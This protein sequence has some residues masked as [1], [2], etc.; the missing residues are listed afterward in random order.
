MPTKTNYDDD[1]YY[2]GDEEDMF[3]EELDDLDGDWMDQAL[4]DYEKEK[5]EEAEREAMREI[6]NSRRAEKKLNQKVEKEEV[7]PEDIRQEMDA[8]RQEANS[9][10][11]AAASV[12]DE[13]TY[14]ADM[15]TKTKED[16]KALGVAIAEHILKQKDRP[17]FS[18]MI[19][20]LYSAL[21]SEFTTSD[22]VDSIYNNVNAICN[23]TKKREKL[24][25]RRGDG[26]V[27]KKNVMTANPEM[28]DFDGSEEVNAV[29]DDSEQPW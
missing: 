9:V 24:Q 23:I 26:P 29:E 14:I 19:A 1:D 13:V 4:E 11:A 7:Q 6:R 2:D 12:G 22:G 25:K 15:P 17:A 10:A 8:L 3:D 16:A 28:P 27:E 5:K 18:V 21:C 20:E